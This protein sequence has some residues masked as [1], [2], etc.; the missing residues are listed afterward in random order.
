MELECATQS[1]PP[2]VICELGF[3]LSLNVAQVNYFGTYRGRVGEE[4]NAARA[5]F[6][7]T[8]DVK[9]RTYQIS[10]AEMEKFFLII[11]RDRR[12]NV[13]EIVPDGSLQVV[14][15]DGG[16]DY[17]KLFSNCKTY[18]LKVFKELGIIEVGAL[19]NFLI[20]R[21][22]THNQLLTP[23]SA[24]V[25]RSPMKEELDIRV[26]ALLARVIESVKSINL[27]DEDSQA[28][29][30]PIQEMTKIIQK[31]LDNKMKIGI[32]QDLN[33]HFT[34]IISLLDY[35]YDQTNIEDIPEISDEITQLYLSANEVA[36]LSAQGQLPLVWKSNFPVA[37]RLNLENFPLEEKAIYSVKIKTNE[38]SDGLEQVLLDVNKKMRQA[39]SFNSNLFLDLT[40]LKAIITEAKKEIDESN[41]TFLAS[42][43]KAAP[44]EI[45]A[46][47]IKRHKE[48]DEITEN[49]EKKINDF[50][51][52]SEETSIFMRYI[53][54]I[55]GYFKKDFITV[56]N[57]KT[58]MKDSIQ[59]MKQSSTLTDIE[60]D[61]SL[62]MQ[63]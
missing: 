45:V 10:Q 3:A 33:I 63:K 17:Q 49:L 47:C 51:P 41:Q 11:N 50:S 46:V 12:I 56:E 37:K 36:N 25:L 29:V 23:L 16:P 59:S 55:I 61:E 38:M 35:I 2:R 8:S 34:E 18:A 32:K 4:A 6:S 5:L 62:R 15:F 31:I 27:T 13:D 39:K 40:D 54:R 42:I 9:H 44:E 21:P 57:I 26:T 20:Q 19:S 7:I 28:L 24:E 22:H 30:T 1:E 58:L 52:Q 60:L 43:E 53:N 48:I 14:K